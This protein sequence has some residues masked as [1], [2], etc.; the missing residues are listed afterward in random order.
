MQISK[1]NRAT[2]GNLALRIVRRPQ[3]RLANLS[4]SRWQ[5]DV[6]LQMNV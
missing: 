6:F 5:L 1:T 2:D 4:A 3:L